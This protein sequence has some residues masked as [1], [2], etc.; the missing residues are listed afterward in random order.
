[1]R[2]L[3]KQNFNIV[4]SASLAA[5]KSWLDGEMAQWGTITQTVKIDA[6]Q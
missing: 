4:P 3:A 5:A 1:V 6:G 2:K